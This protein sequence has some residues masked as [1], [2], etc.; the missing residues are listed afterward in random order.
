MRGKSRSA[1]TFACTT[2]NDASVRTTAWGI[3]SRIARNRPCS[4]SATASNAIEVDREMIRGTEQDPQ[5]AFARTGPR[6]HRDA[7]DLA[8]SPLDGDDENVALRRG[9][10][11]ALESVESGAAS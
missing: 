3:E 9:G 8:P 10:S 7:H 2:R 6:Q 4:A 1:E 5:D 11:R